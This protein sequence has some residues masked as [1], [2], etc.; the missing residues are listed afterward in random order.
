[1]TEFVQP[2]GILCARRFVYYARESEATFII[3]HAPIRGEL[4]LAEFEAFG[5]RGRALSLWGTISGEY[6]NRP[7]NFE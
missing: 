5:L 2:P 6:V 7:L 3:L 4:L 1:M